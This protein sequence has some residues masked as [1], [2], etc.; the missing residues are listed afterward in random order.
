VGER[1]M[2][3]FAFDPYNLLFTFIVIFG[4]Q[5]L[6]FAFAMTLHTDKLTDISYGM[7]FIIMVIIFLFTRRPVRWPKVAAA[8]MIVVWGLRLAGYLFV[9]IIRIG[10][11]ERFDDKR[12]SFKNFGAF[13]LL[14]AVSVWI[15][16]LPLTFL[17]GYE[18]AARWPWVSAVGILVWAAGFAVEAAADRQKYRF[19]NKPE[20]RGRWIDTGLWKYSRHPNYFGEILCWWG[21]FI[22]AIPYLGGIGWT[23]II[24]PVHITILLIFVSGIPLLEK[25]ADGKYGDSDEYREYKRRTSVLVPLPPKK[26]G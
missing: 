3:V 4:I 22:L 7:T 26:K 19:K 5:L 6:C 13:W 9:R 25:K 11:D 12:D 23:G 2:H 17:F 20:N 21:L 14:Q 18:D 8:A 10:K 24:G 16:L 15:I 1:K